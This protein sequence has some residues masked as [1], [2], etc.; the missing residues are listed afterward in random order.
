MHREAVSNLQGHKMNGIYLN[1]HTKSTAFGSIS[2]ELETYQRAIQNLLE[3]PTELFETMKKKNRQEAI[4]QIV[5]FAKRNVIEDKQWASSNQ[6]DALKSFRHQI[7]DISDS[8]INNHVSKSNNWSYKIGFCCHNCDFSWE[9]QHVI[10][11]LL[12]SLTDPYRFL[13][14]CEM[15]SPPSCQCPS[16]ELFGNADVQMRIDTALTGSVLC[17]QKAIDNKC[18]WQ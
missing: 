18:S 7:L 17:D 8:I 14:S 6:H 4:N 13:D 2:E 5:G 1:G 12:K 9:V 10:N 11:D 16:T 15:K 3:M